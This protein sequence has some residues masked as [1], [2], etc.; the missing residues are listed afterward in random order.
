YV[1]AAV[2]F[3]MTGVAFSVIFSREAGRIPQL[4]GADL[5]GGALACLAVVPLLNWLG[6]PNAILF[7]AVAVAVAGAVW[8]GPGRGRTRHL[9]LAA[10]IAAVIVANYSGRLID[11]VYAKGVLR[12]RSWVEFARWNAISRV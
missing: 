11:V 9:V 12:D 4:Y 10:V 7:A 6:G 3:F 5:L 2:P 1:A 8:D